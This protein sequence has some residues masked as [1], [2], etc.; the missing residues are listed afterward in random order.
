M[1]SSKR[2][3]LV[4][5]EVTSL[6]GPGVYD[7]PSKFGK[8]GVKFTFQGKKEH[9]YGTLSPGPGAYDAKDTLVKDSISQVAIS[10]T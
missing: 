9:S 6:P 3:E 1:G 8:E 2:Q 10:S 4:S 5:K 7:S